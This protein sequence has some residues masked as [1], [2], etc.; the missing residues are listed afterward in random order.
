V[1]DN[2]AEI[3]KRTLVIILIL[4]TS[5][6][7]MSLALL[8]LESQAILATYQEETE[9]NSHAKKINLAIIQLL[10]QT[11][12]KFTDLSAVAINEGPGSFTGL[13]VGSS[14]AKGICFA[15]NIPMIAISGLVAYGNYLYSEKPDDVTDVFILMDAR[16]SNYFYTHISEYGQ[17]A[18]PA[19]NSLA[20]IENE[21]KECQHPRIYYIDKMDIVQ[22]SAEKLKQ[23]VLEKWK[24]QDFVHLTSF[25][26][27][28]LIN[29]YLVKK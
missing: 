28:Y 7:K 4:D 11:A 15:L 22:L 16:R 29:N 25:E 12:H 26:P 10:E 20:N 6:K 1:S 9:E 23:A 3:I 19:F 2:F 8:D 17:E 5:T 24:S 18:I 21:A 14:T 13:R 27:M